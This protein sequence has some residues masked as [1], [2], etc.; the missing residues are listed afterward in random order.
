MARTPRRRTAAFS[1][2]KV[3]R[4]A[5]TT[6]IATRNSQRKARRLL[7]LQVG[8][9]QTANQPA[10]TQSIEYT[11]IECPIPHRGTTLIMSHAPI[12][13]SRAAH[14]VRGQFQIGLS[15]L[16]LLFLDVGRGALVRSLRRGN[17]FAYRKNCERAR[18]VQQRKT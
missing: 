13:L 6:G 10:R 15:H 3:V 18:R 2:A 9:I 17:G 12:G 1:A 16:K 7:H 4:I 8:D 11:G 5:S 14:D